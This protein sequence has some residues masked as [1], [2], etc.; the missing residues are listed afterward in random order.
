MAFRPGQPRPYVPRATVNGSPV[1]LPI[2][3]DMLNAITQAIAGGVTSVWYA[4]RRV[5]FMSLDDLLKAWDWIAGQLGL[6][7]ADRP[8]RSYACF[9]K[10]LTG[11]G[12]AGIEHAEVAD[13]LFSRQVPPDP[14]REGDV[15][16]E[17]AR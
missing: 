10:G 14:T 8:R 6:L 17:R 9:S 13:V 16:W 4:D 11:Y 2:T 7:E 12:G 3:V 1:P 15:D 5:N